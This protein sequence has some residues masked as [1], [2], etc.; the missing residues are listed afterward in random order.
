MKLFGIRTELSHYKDFYRK[1]VD[2]RNEKNQILMNKPIYQ[3]LSIFKLNKIVIDEFWYN[4]VKPTYG[5]K[6]K[7]CFMD[8]DR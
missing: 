4:Y 7:L 6:A 1:F 8:T 3:G 2:Y 5:E